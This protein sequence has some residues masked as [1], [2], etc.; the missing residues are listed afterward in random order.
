MQVLSRGPFQ[1]HED[2]TASQ[3]CIAAIDCLSAWTW[4]LASNQPNAKQPI[5]KLTRNV[6]GMGQHWGQRTAAAAWRCHSSTTGLEEWEQ[7]EGVALGTVGSNLENAGEGIHNER[8]GCRRRLMW[9]GG[10]LP[11]KCKVAVNLSRRGEAKGPTTGAS[12]GGSSRSPG[13]PGS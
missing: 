11:W 8:E 2:K 4:P 3:L 6:A 7:R 12:T 13:T 10:R 5:N 9:L 1:T